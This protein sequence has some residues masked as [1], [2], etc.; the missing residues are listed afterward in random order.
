MSESLSDISRSASMAHRSG[1]T[2][3]SVLVPVYN[4]EY[5]VAAS[6]MRLRVL[7]NSALIQRIQIIVVDDSSTDQIRVILNNFAHE[8]K[9]SF[10]SDKFEWIFLR[11]ENN[12]GKGGA[13]RTALEHAECELTV[14]H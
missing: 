6:L 5:L 2:T 1:Q 3:L 12:Q 14:I 9:D 13:I 10:E 4:E 8:C 7:G 11:H